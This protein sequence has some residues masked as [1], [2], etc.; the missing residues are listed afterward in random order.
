M[1]FKKIFRFFD[2]LEDKIRHSLSHWPILYALVG[3]LGIVL[4]WRGVWH[5]ADDFGL[6]SWLSILIGVIILLST[7]LLVAVAIGDEVIISAF[8]GRRKITEIRIEE[9]LTLVERVEEIKNLLDKIESRLGTIK[10]EEEKIAKD[11]KEKSD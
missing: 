9:A 4:T 2:V 11:L 8:R 7:G 5:L 6:N 1:F 3:I 10:K